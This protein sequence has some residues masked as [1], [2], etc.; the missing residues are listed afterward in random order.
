MVMF[1]RLHTKLVFLIGCFVLFV[2]IAVSTPLV[3]VNS[4]TSEAAAIGIATRQQTLILRI[5]NQTRDLIAALES[6]SS[7]TEKSQAL[8][9]SSQLFT[10][11][12]AALRQG[13]MTVDSAEQSITL[14]PSAPAIADKFAQVQDVW[15]PTYE[16]L[17]VLTDPNLDI[18]SDRFYDA[19]ELIQEH[20]SNIFTLS[21]QA[22]TALENAST[23]KVY[24][25]KAILLSTLA[26]SIVAAFFALWFGRRSLIR[27][28]HIVINAMSTMCYANDTDFN[29]RLPDF[30]SD[31]VGDI[32]RLVNAICE[33]LQMAYNDI[34][35]SN[36]AML[37]IKQALDNTATSVIIL[38]KQQ[39]IIYFNEATKTIFKRERLTLV[40]HFG[41][42][43]Q[44]EQLSKLSFAELKVILEGDLPQNFDKIEKTVTVKLRIGNSLLSCQITPVIDEQAQH[45]GWVLEWKDITLEIAIEQEVNQVMMAASQGDFSTRINVQ[46][47]HGFF[48]TLSQSI[49][50]T[51]TTNQYILTELSRLFASMA[52]GDLSQSLKGDY[53]GALAHL[54]QDV[55]AMTTQLN[56]VML[57][58]QDSA[59]EVNNAAEHILKGSESLASSSNQRT[60]SLEEVAASIEEMTTTMQH[61]TENASSLKEVAQNVQKQTKQG[62]QVIAEMIQAMQGIAESS[63]KVA[64][65]TSLIDEIAFQTNL[66]ALN[67]AVEAARAGEQGRSFA[68]VAAEVRQLAQRSASAAKDIRTLI[69]DSTQRINTGNNLASQ[70][71]VTLHAI[72]N[73]FGQV[74]VMIQEIVNSSYEQSE[75]IQ[76]INR[77]VMQIEQS[78]QQNLN[79]VNEAEHASHSMKAQ[80]MQLREMVNFFQLMGTEES[81]ADL[82]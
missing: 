63:H 17:L 61:N 13:G 26:L 59:R 27:P 24:W 66:L 18:I 48:L 54:K 80:A 73:L 35:S 9:A 28:M 20:W 10:N 47:K 71:E 33:K 74:T 5:Q 15:L 3:V 37:R 14:P 8:L 29:R 50:E 53:R 76:L 43:W 69:Q 12:L 34:Q 6:E 70:S 40:E 82:A 77:A 81:E 30:G 39:N 21:Q 44:L 36:I 45:L 79:V 11:S 23:Q 52:Q 60:A 72:Q 7:T 4:Q 38:N 65:I 64:D 41:A 68:V 57:V 78:S 22:A 55:N 58:I 51:L 31:E 75:G 67:A 32:A 56:E 1:N 19:I 42:D 25:L 49:N 16:A 46:D 2:L 62:S